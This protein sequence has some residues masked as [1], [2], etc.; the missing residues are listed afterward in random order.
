MKSNLLISSVY[1]VKGSFIYLKLVSQETQE[2][3]ADPTLKPDFCIFQ[4]KWL[5]LSTM[6]T[7]PIEGHNVAYQCKGLDQSNIVCKYEVNLP[8]NEKVIIKKQNF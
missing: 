3:N 6:Q 5:L 7:L 8:S 1:K 2:R 4:H